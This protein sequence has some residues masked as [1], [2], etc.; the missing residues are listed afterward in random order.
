[1]RNQGKRPRQGRRRKVLTLQ[2]ISKKNQTRENILTFVR[3]KGQRGQ[4]DRRVELSD[5]MKGIGNENEAMGEA[6]TTEWLAVN[7]GDQRRKDTSMYS[8]IEPE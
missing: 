5:R 4:G 7:K 1:M 6:T 2:R 3:D 8:G